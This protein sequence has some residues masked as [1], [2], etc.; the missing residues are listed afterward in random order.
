[1]MQPTLSQYRDILDRIKAHKDV[2][3]QICKNNT[4]PWSDEVL[5]QFDE[6]KYWIARYENMLQLMRQ[7]EREQK[8]HGG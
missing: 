8:W 5:D 1:M 7:T 6:I 2:R 4:P 3:D